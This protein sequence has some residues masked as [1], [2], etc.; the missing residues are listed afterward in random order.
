MRIRNT[1]M[2][3]RRTKKKPSVDLGGWDL[4][5]H[6]VSPTGLITFLEC[7]EQ[8]RLTTCLRY[9]QLRKPV[10][11]TFGTLIH[12]FLEETL[13][14][15]RKPPT[16]KKIDRLAE[17]WHSKEKKHYL[18]I[19]DQERLDTLVGLAIAVFNGYVLRYRGDWTRSKKDYPSPVSVRPKKWFGFETKYVYRYRY[20]DGKETNINLRFDALFYTASNLWIQETKCWS[21]IKPEDITATLGWDL[22]FN[23]YLLALQQMQ[24]DIVG[25]LVL[26]VIRRPGHAQKKTETRVEFNNRVLK[27]ILNPSKWDHF[28]QRFTYADTTAES[29]VWKRKQLDPIMELLR[30]WFEQKIPHFV[31]PTG[32]LNKYGRCFMFEPIVYKNFSNMKRGKLREI[33]YD[34]EQ[35]K[36]S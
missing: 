14:Q 20:P 36:K 19:R 7:F 22:Q 5:K 18:T 32:L 21:V 4:W 27:E 9:R 16:A 25:G 2:T 33:K 28:F 11:P 13:P 35:I 10:G 34:E 30:L 26:N 31:R 23:M 29:T 6:G 1:R 3:I 17:R 24:D 15:Q 8:F 12:Y